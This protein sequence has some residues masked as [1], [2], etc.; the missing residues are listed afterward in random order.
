MSDRPLDVSTLGTIIGKLQNASSATAHGLHEDARDDAK[1][2]GEL[3]IG[4]L[5]WYVGTQAPIVRGSRGFGSSSDAKADPLVA[6]K[7]RLGIWL[8]AETGRTWDNGADADETSWDVTLYEAN[9]D[10]AH[11]P[12]R[13]AARGEGGS[14]A[15]AL[16]AALSAANGGDRG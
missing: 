4:M 11:E 6:A 13:V 16:L 12:L 10:D 1:R 5:G 7:E 15:D 3:L 9:D 8:S 14:L 2:A